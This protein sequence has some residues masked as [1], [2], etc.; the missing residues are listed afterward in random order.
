M[1]NFNKWWNNLTPMEKQE[2]TNKYYCMFKQVFWKDVPNEDI[3]RMFNW[4]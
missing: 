2:R 4:S 3:K 1:K